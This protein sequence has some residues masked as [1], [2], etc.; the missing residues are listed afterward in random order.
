MSSL[1]VEKHGQLPEAPGVEGWREEIWVAEQTRGVASGSREIRLEVMGKD[2]L[3]T[4]VEVRGGGWG[5]GER[6]PL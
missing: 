4:E 6:E 3:W 5:G 1:W 2:D